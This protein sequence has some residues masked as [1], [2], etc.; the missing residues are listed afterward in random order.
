MP[1]GGDLGAVGEVQPTHTDPW[2]RLVAAAAVF[3][4]RG[5]LEPRQ[6]EALALLCEALYRAATARRTHSDLGRLL[7]TL[8]HHTSVVRGWRVLLLFR[9]ARTPRRGFPLLATLDKVLGAAPERTGVVLRTEAARELFRLTSDAASTW[10]RLAAEPLPRPGLHEAAVDAATL[11]LRLAAAAGQWQEHDRLAA[12]IDETWL[13]T[14]GEGSGHVAVA[15]A[16]GEVTQGRYAR[17][18]ERLRAYRT[19]EDVKI[20]LASLEISLRT[21]VVVSD[22]SASEQVAA[23]ARQVAGLLRTL[24]AEPSPDGADGGRDWHERSERARYLLSFLNH[25]GPPADVD[26][27][28]PLVRA[29]ALADERPWEALTIAESTLRDPPRAQTPEESI[30]LRLLWTRLGLNLLGPEL[31]EAAEEITSGAI[32]EARRRGLP[33]L[34]MDAWDLRAIVHARCFSD[35]WPDAMADA[36][37]AANLAVELLSRNEESAVERPLR[38]QLLPILDRAVDL[39]AEG[40]AR[41]RT[42]PAAAAGTWERFGRAALEY[43]EQSMELALSEARRMRAGSTGPREVLLPAWRSVDLQAE[44]APHEAVLQY[45]LVTRYLLVFT[46]GVNFFAWH[47]EEIEPAEAVP[48]SVR[49]TTPSRR[50][51]EPL[52]PLAG[53][54]HRADPSAARDATTPPRTDF[55]QPRDL[56]APRPAEIYPAARA[57][58]LARRVLP[59]SIVG[60]LERMRIRRL[61]VVPHDIL[62]RA[63]FGQ[64]PWRH[65]T[66]GSCFELSVHPTGKL[67]VRHTAASS[68]RRPRIGFF[69]GAGLEAA[70]REFWAL[71]SAW[72]DGD[73]VVE[74]DTSTREGSFVQ[75]AGGFD[76]LYLACH[77]SPPSTE[78][79]DEFLALGPAGQVV[80]LSEV[81]ALDLRRCRLAVVQ[82][83]WTGWM[84]HRRELP[85]QG[86]PQALRDAGVA[87]VVAPMF[88]VMD[89]LCPVFTAVYARALRFLSA[90]RALGYT[91][92]VLRRHGQSLCAAA[93]RAALD[94]SLW[95]G[96]HTFEAY[97]YRF[98]GDAGVSLGGSW[99]SRCFRRLHFH[100]WLQ[101]ARWRARG[102]ETGRHGRP[103]FEPSDPAATAP[104]TRT[105][106]ASRA[107]R[108]CAWRPRRRRTRSLALRAPW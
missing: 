33:L 75:E 25:H 34:E 82:A 4:V 14:A 16:E 91:L 84:E 1:P 36:G 31:G 28:S 93:G 103:Q 107:P 81:A 2:R 19:V 105:G 44:C 46:Y 53:A 104:R 80:H 61:A 63:P 94:P 108:A 99:I 13:R 68:P 102:I 3:A 10:R 15:I 7:R 67:A 62:Y 27:A 100:A 76:A 42:N 92:N 97:E 57:A 85:V 9:A 74:R 5:S 59:S 52:L 51:V 29:L 79:A 49:E 69:Q 30:R 83:C 48:G 20:R 78:P 71:A 40:A 90:N 8:R 12:E 24:L 64:L 65:S 55:G 77:G 11:R 87:A 54:L 41:T 66:L 106:A 89:A 70:P 6:A 50:L 60:A 98:A 45:F 26:Q 21:L 96:P 73:N 37:H 95:R 32:E 43:A 88:P 38:V 72:G 35:R 39:L 101:A 47:L 22:G 58:A 56:Y 18:I 86:F 23:D 17:A